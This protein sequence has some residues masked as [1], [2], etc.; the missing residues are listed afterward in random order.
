M[1]DMESAK[2]YVV[3]V[4][5]TPGIYTSWIDCKLQ[6]D[7]VPN[8]KY[9][10]Y[11]SR[12]EAEQAYKAGYGQALYAAK[13]G[14]TTTKLKASDPEPFD[15]HSIC[16]DAA[17][18]GNPGPVEYQGVDT[19]TGERLFHY[20]PI[21]RGT[22]NLGE[23]LAIVHGLGYLQRQKSPRI[24]YTD[25]N[26]ALKWVREKHV[27]TTLPRDETTAEIWSLIDRATQ[28]LQTN[29]YSNPI[30]KWQTEMWGEIKADFGRK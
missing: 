28:W 27:A 24:I 26:T 3:W 18:S 20:G 10:S 23:F 11:K 14:K 6:I 15:L 19:Q 29:T 5:K 21:A 25:S 1:N 2:F 16:V 12:A 4:G 30:L 7:E 9:K 22:N 8:A 13:Q 17:S